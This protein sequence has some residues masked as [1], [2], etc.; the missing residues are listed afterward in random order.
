MG[1][2]VGDVGTIFQINV[3]EDIS[4]ATGREIFFKKS[5]GVVL[6]KTATF[7][8]SSGVDGVIEYI[9]TTGVIDIAGNWELQGHLVIG[10]TDYATE[11]GKFTVSARLST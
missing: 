7:T 5:N 4:T 6:T 2:F 3:G 11:I 9:G 1:V 10:A 8:T